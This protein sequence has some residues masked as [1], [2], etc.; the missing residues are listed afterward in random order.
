M[1]I[2]TLPIY[3]QNPEENFKLLLKYGRK[4]KEDLSKWKCIP[5][6]FLI[7]FY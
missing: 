3:N 1:E 5:Y 6:S 7:F 4:K 2:N